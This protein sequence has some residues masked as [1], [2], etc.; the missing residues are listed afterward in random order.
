MS[1]P[2]S[3]N[4]SQAGAL[5]HGSARL[6]LPSARGRRPNSV[7]V[8]LGRRGQSHVRGEKGVSKTPQPSP[9]RTLRQSPVNGYDLFYPLS[10]L[11]VF[12]SILVP[13]KYFSFDNVRRPAKAAVHPG[14]DHRGGR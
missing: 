9:P 10:R 2:K 6:A 5:A 14:G 3:C 11:P 4:R 12:H 7:P 1:L 13:V 8:R